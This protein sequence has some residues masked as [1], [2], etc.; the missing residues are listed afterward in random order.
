[1]TSSVDSILKIALTGLNT[2]QAALG[3]TSNNIANVNTPGFVR[4]EIVQES[5]LVGSDEGG[6][7][8][9]AIRRVTDEFLIKQFLSATADARNF[10]A[11][12]A[13]HDQ[14]QTILGRPD[15]NTA[16]SGRIND[17]FEG[18]ADLPTEP[19]STV[20]RIAALN[21]IQAFADEV[22]RTASFIQELRRE[23]DRQVQE[24]VTTIND[25]IARVHELNPLVARE[26]LAGRDG[27]TLEEQRA[28]AIEQIAEQV[29]I[30][31]FDIGNGFIGVTTV[32]GVTLVNHLARSLTYEP[33]GTVASTTRFPEITVSKVDPITGVIDAVGTP[34][35]RGV[36]SG[37][38]RGLLDMR[39]VELPN[40]AE[41][42]G[43][44]SSRVIDR[45]NAAHNDNSAVPPPSALV[46]RN[47]GLLAADAHGFTGTVNLATIDATNAI[48]N[49]VAIDFTAGTIATNGGGA[50]ALSGATIGDVINDVNGALGAGS[51]TLVGGVLTF[52]APGGATGVATLDDATTP[53]SRGS[54]GFAHFFGLN[55]LVEATVN[56]HADTGL[57]ATDSHGFANGEAFRLQLRGANNEIAAD[58]TVTFPLAG[59]TVQDLLT[60]LKTDFTGLGQFALDTNGALV[61]TPATSQLDS[62]LAVVSDTTDRGG[63]GVSASTLFGIGVNFV[64]DA[65]LAVKV[66]DAFRSNTSLLALGK[67][68]LTGQPALT[69][70]DGRGAL[71]FLAIADEA[72][73]FSAVGNLS[74]TTTSLTDYAANVISDIAVRA[75]QALALESDTEALESALEV[76]ISQVSGVNLDEELGNMVLFQNA[77]NA[78]ARMIATA[79]E[80]FEVLLQLA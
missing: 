63:T 52:Q 28:R 73:S 71:A 30:Q 72:V 20:R 2:S 60:Q 61:F 77:F 40:F 47:T 78:S 49:R 5:Q 32:S 36:R 41:E 9:G 38:L 1:M 76:R 69:P 4:R 18:L 53:S 68:D 66:K 58:V 25:A 19:D 44:L 80:M 56:S 11:Q 27:N 79:R 8:I 13:L 57:V 59:G 22:S 15:E 37:K 42:I 26:F 24:S 45:L 55:D 65:A 3:T 21:G 6:V 31:T 16:F 50:V 51:M 70:G 48:V 43:H 23:A 17:I 64:A 62:Q 67:L 35:D 14:L 10:G 34:L 75:E 12:T 29:D 54:R 74:A 33:P 46:G 7:R 39:N